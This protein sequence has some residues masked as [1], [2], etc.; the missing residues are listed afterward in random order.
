VFEPLL[1][2]PCYSVALCC[3]CYSVALCCPCYSVSHSFC[4]GGTLWLCGWLVSTA[5]P[6]EWQRFSL[7][8]LLCFPGE[9]HACTSYN[10]SILFLFECDC[11]LPRP[12]LTAG[13]VCACMSYYHVNSKTLYRL[14][15][16]WC[17]SNVRI[18]VQCAGRRSGCQQR[19]QARHTAVPAIQR[20][21]VPAG[22][23]RAC[24]HGSP[25]TTPLP[26]HDAFHQ[27]HH[28]H[29]TTHCTGAAWA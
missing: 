23:G 26:L 28:W 10:N 4:S 25:V 9:A 12:R 19:P 17:R 27:P 22:M 6:Y 29:V 7:E 21:P 24:S 1:C 13:V 18:P 16:L 5:V 20:I 14:G 3:P 11:T 8:H 15:R 2:C